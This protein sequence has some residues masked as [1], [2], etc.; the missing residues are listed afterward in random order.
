MRV[1]LSVVLTSAIVL[2]IGLITLLGMTV[3]NDFGGLT[4][5]VT[6]TP[7]RLLTE[8]FL[9]L[10]SL[11]L[12]LSVLVGVLNLFVVNISRVV[13]GR[14]AGARLGSLL[15]VASFL[16]VVFLRVMDSVNATRNLAVF[17][18]TVQVP[19]E[20]SLA[21]LLFFALVWGGMR[22]LRRGLTFGRVMF[23]AAML[24][25]LL[26]ALPVRGVG[27]LYELNNWLLNVPV[28]AGARG[29]L[30]GVGLATLIAGVR[31]LIGQDRQYGE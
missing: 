4:V 22:V 6:A 15:I 10:A 12:A 30:L 27:L 14:T 18:E 28:S 17:T 9:R 23:V 1:R 8:I 13:R 2:G 5:L 31:V 25:V 16:L 19:L 21:G 26:G 3:G 29:I 11:V 20:A 7:I 24:V